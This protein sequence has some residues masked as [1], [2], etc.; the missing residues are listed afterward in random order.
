MITPEMPFPYSQD[1]D[2][3]WSEAGVKRYPMLTFFAGLL[4]GLVGIGGGMVLGPLL[5]EIGMIP[6]V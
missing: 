3:R 2:I 4:A 6:Q 1:G 5:L